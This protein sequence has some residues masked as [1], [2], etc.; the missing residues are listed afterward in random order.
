MLHPFTPERKPIP[1]KRE[2]CRPQGID[3]MEK[4]KYLATD[5]N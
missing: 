5:G 1:I 4:I 2:L 3:V